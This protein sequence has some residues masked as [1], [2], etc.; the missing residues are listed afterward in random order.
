VQATADGGVATFEDF[1][2]G[3]Y[4]RVHVER[5]QI[6]SADDLYLDAR[7]MGAGSGQWAVVARSGDRGTDAALVSDGEDA[8][9]WADGVTQIELVDVEGTVHDTRQVGAQTSSRRDGLSVRAQALVGALPATLRLVSPEDRD[10]V[11][12]EVS[13]AFGR[14]VVVVE[15]SAA[16]L[17]ALGNAMRRVTVTAASAVGQVVFL[18]AAND[19]TVAVEAGVGESDEGLGDL[20]RRLLQA[21]VAYDR[22]AVWVDASR[23]RL[24]ALAK[25]GDERKALARDVAR[26][27]GEAVVFVSRATRDVTPPGQP[28]VR[29]PDDFPEEIA[30]LLRDALHKALAEAGLAGDYSDF[31]ASGDARA[32]E[33]GFASTR[34]RVGA[35]HDFADYLAL[36][37]VPEAYPVSA[38]AGFDG[39]PLEQLEVRRMTTLVKVFAVFG[40]GLVDRA[41]LAACTGDLDVTLSAPG[42]VVHKPSGESVTFASDVQAVRGPYY[43]GATRWAATA[44]RRGMEIALLQLVYRDPVPE[45]VRLRAVTGVGSNSAQ[46]RQSASFSVSTPGE[47]DV[48]AAGGGLLLI[49]SASRDRFEGILLGAVLGAEALGARTF[50]VV[51]FRFDA[52]LWQDGVR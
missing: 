5:G 8:W 21:R 29:L 18:E 42:I 45:L 19:R 47:G 41:A 52:P 2:E 6:T 34:G 30:V 3:H 11:P 49:R 17:E 4:V 39:R 51:L 50:P 48:A 22:T 27:V 26:A 24:E 33:D 46:Q 7:P 12:P 31:P 43:A 1:T 20:S 32:V 40:L 10:D 15:P 36:L 37:A 25:S 13:R 44:N 28:E 14:A 16:A 9:V 38:C 35:E 23:A